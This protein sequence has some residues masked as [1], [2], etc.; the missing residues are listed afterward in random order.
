MLKYSQSFDKQQ[1][2]TISTYTRSV[3]SKVA[4]T[5]FF[6]QTCSNVWVKSAWNINA[7][8]VRAGTQAQWYI[9]SKWWSRFR[10]GN[11]TWL[12]GREG[13]ELNDQHDWTQQREDMKRKKWKHCIWDGVWDVTF[14]HAT[15]FTVYTCRKM[16]SLCVPW[17]TASYTTFHS[18]YSVHP[19]SWKGKMHIQN[20]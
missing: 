18:T 12:G 19:T 20:R 6:E 7:V 11:W 10:D 13:G 5:L 4:L 15:L 1:L 9:C 14:I 3:N 8:R 17:K 2:F 16:V